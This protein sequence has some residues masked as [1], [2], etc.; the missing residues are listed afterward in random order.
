[1]IFVSCSSGLH[2]ET[3]VGPNGA[4]SP[5]RLFGGDRV[6]DVVISMAKPQPSE[7]V[8]CD[9]GPKGRAN[10][11]NVG[12]R[13]W[14]SADLKEV[15]GRPDGWLTLDRDDDAPRVSPD[16]CAIDDISVAEEH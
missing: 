15:N 5:G 8:L 14:G 6:C 16:D 7:P 11:W 2:G 10:D 13:R 4:A 1:V 12:H 3:A 9:H